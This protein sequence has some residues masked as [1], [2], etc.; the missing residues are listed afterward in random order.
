MV[1]FLSVHFSRS[2]LSYILRDPKY[3]N[4]D[5]KEVPDMFGRANSIA[6]LAV[7]VQSTYIGVLL[8]TFGR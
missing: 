2:F 1:T 6:E 3:Y 4:I 8:D 5:A 7:I